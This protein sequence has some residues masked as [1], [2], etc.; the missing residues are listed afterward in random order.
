MK[1]NLSGNIPT[2][3]G[4]STQLR[5]LDVLSNLLVEEIPKE[6]RKLK[7]LLKLFLIDQISGFVPKELRSLSKLLYL[8]LSANKLSGQ[9]KGFLWD[10]LH[11]FYLNLGNNQFGGEIPIHITKIDS[12]LV[13][14]LAS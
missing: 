2:V 9:I 4:N 14:S 6:L 10:Y 13:H 1:K 3:F 5:E 8:N 11:L 7:Y 12:F